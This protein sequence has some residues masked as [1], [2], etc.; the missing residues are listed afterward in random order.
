MII[1]ILISEIFLFSF[2]IKFSSTL[3]LKRKKNNRKTKN[4]SETKKSLK[5]YIKNINPKNKKYRPTTLS[6]KILRNLKN[7]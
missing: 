2:K 3:T 6:L 5:N 7:S 1:A 4:L